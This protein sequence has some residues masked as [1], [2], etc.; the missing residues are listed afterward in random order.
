MKDPIKSSRYKYS[1]SE[2]E[3]LK[4]QKMQEKDLNLLS[5]NMISQEE[6]IEE[7]R[8]RVETLTAQ[9][10]VT[11]AP[12]VASSNIPQESLKIRRD[13][14]PSWESLV[15]RANS[16]ITKNIVFEDL[17]SQEE[18]NYC[19]ED[20]KRINDEFERRTKL[21]KL[22]ASFIVVATALQTA[23]WILIQYFAGDLGQKINKDTRL[24]H[25]DPRIK[26]DVYNKNK[27]FQDTFSEHGHRKSTKSYRTWE[28]I[29]FSSVPYDATIGANALYGI[30]ME[31]KYHRYKTLGH[32]PVLGW[33]FGTLN[34]ITNTIT[35]SDF[36]SFRVLSGLKFGA[37]T[38][39]GTILYET[40]DSIREDWLRLPAAI[41]AQYVHLKSDAFTKQGLPIPLL[42]VFSEKLAGKLYKSQYDSL[43]LI[44]DVAIIHSQAFI[45][46][47]I[48]MIIDLVHGLFYDAERDGEKEFYE[49]RTRKIIAISNALASAG[50]ITYAACSEDWKK[51]DIGGI[52]ISLK[53]LFCDTLF[54]TRLKEK[55]IQE[56]LDKVIAKEIKEI[57]SNFI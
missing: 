30:P 3:L 51:L 47:F 2:K 16:E 37:P 52:L 29:I 12:K 53:R 46:L 6:E 23:R 28:E 48:N 32:D 14:I 50:N 17:L 22:D 45:S 40:F 57:E 8:K 1:E 34:I 39:I 10:G 25:N 19:I 56:E 38:N 43:C 20:V 9:V 13:E 27:T 54:I 21:N 41:F 36:S 49:V 11:P 4:I 33:I 26:E 18:L 24:D 15:E 44:K 31:G 55:F 5:K 35:L 7:I 42:E